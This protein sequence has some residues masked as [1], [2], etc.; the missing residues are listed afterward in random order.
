M[1]EV[2]SAEPIIISKRK[3]A[4]SMAMKIMIRVSFDSAMAIEVDGVE[5]A[6]DEDS[7]EVGTLW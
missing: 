4:T 2:A 7:P 5:I 3:N 6:V 1:V